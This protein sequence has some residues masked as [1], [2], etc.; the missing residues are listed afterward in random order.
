MR[1]EEAYAGW[2]E[3][4]LTQEE[5]ALLLGVCART[6][7]RYIDRFEKRGGEWRIAH[8]QV[9]Y[10]WSKIEPIAAEYPNEQ[11]EHGKRSREDASYRR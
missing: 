9:V 8:R 2:Q 3:R 10:D 1:F 11:F 6:F 7:R 4:R 5:A